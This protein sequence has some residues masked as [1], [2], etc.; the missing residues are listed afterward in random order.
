M[1]AAGKAEGEEAILVLGEKAKKR[2]RQW[3]VFSKQVP[4]LKQTTAWHS[5]SDKG[6]VSKTQENNYI[7][8]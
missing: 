2:R 7:M 8:I 1:C 5:F 3:P 4:N 6:K